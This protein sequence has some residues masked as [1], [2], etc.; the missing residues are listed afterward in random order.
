MACAAYLVS[1]A[2]APITTA[3]AAYSVSHAALIRYRLHRLI[4][5]SRSSNHHLM[6]RLLGQSHIPRHHRMRRLLGQSHTSTA[7]AA[8]SVS[9]AA[10]IT[11]ACALLAPPVSRSWGKSRSS[12]RLCLRRLS[13]AA[14]QVRQLILPLL[15][16]FPPLLAPPFSLLHRAAYSA[17]AQLRPPLPL[18]PPSCLDPDPPRVSC[19]APPAITAGSACCT[20]S[21]LLRQSLPDPRAVFLRRSSG[22][23]CRIRVLHSLDQPGEFHLV[24][25]GCPFHH[26]GISV[27]A[28]QRRAGPPLHRQGIHSVCGAPHDETGS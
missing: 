24:R 1:H 3:C 7:C 21:P 13:A 9:H 25:H 28:R 27:L 5:Q 17:V 6:R 26:E 10:P 23:H 12:Y 8:Y 14:G 19:A 11:T 15:P 18:A 2:A 4:G 22:N 16:S 20:S